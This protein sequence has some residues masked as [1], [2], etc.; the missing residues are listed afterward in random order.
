MDR[1]CI[2]ISSSVQATP[3]SRYGWIRNGGQVSPYLPHKVD[4]AEA[5]HI[6]ADQRKRSILCS[7][8]VAAILRLNDNPN[9]GRNVRGDHHTRT[10]SKSGWLVG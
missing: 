10:I 5:R 7:F 4:R 6:S 9:T 3:D 1:R 2:E 8:H